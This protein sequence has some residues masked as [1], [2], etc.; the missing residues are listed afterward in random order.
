MESRSDEE[1]AC[2]SLSQQ[3]LSIC[4]DLVCPESQ[5][6]PKN[7]SQFLLKIKLSL[8][9]SEKLLIRSVLNGIS[10]LCILRL[11][12]IL[13]VDR[14]QK[15]S[16]TVDKGESQRMSNIIFSFL[17]LFLASCRLFQL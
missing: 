11:H 9:S 17:T 5:S 16:I 12:Q 7:C 13:E 14:E 4:S 15:L 3:L 8:F 2:S 10:S 6:A 1:I